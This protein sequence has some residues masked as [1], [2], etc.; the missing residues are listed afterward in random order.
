MKNFSYFP[1]TAQKCTQKHNKLHYQH[2]QEDSDSQLRGTRTYIKCKSAKD[3]TLNFQD[4]EPKNYEKLQ[5]DVT[6]LEYEVLSFLDAL[7]SDRLRV[8]INS[9]TFMQRNLFHE[10]HI[11]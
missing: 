1:F 2:L 8:D 9:N 7:K 5:Q 4:V 11:K 10:T 6:K 3:G